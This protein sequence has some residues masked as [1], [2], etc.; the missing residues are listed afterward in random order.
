MQRVWTGVLAAG[1]GAVVGGRAA[2]RLWGLPLEVPRPGRPEPPIDIYV[3]RHR[4][5]GTCGPAWRLIRGDREGTASPPRTS[6]AQTVVDLA[7]VLDADELAGLVGQAIARRRVSARAIR[8]AL[9]ATPRHPHHALLADVV[10]DAADGT[11]GAL[12]RRYLLHVERAHGPPRAEHQAAPEELYRVDN[13][14]R[15]HTLIVECDSQAYPGRVASAKDMERDRYHESWGHMTL[16]FTWAD[17]AGD[18]CGTARVVA[19]RLGERGWPGAL[20][21]CV[22]CVE[23]LSTTIPKSSPHK[24]AAETRV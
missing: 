15:A 14:Y 6:R 3:G 24:P 21:P 10:A 9:D 23:K 16:R 13:L 17:V 8:A 22:H 5:P 12:E 7:R 2:A 1:P 20:R 4:H 18:P 19:E 11:A